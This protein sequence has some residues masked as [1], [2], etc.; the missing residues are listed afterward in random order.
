MGGM[1]QRRKLNGKSLV[2]LERPQVLSTKRRKQSLAGLR[3][4]VG[5]LRRAAG[6]LRRAGET[7]REHSGRQGALR[8]GLRGRKRWQRLGP[9]RGGKGKI[10]GA[11]GREGLRDWEKGTRDCRVGSPRPDS[12]PRAARTARE[13]GASA[14]LTPPACPSAGAAGW[15]GLRGPGR[16]RRRRGAGGGRVGAGRVRS[17]PGGGAGGRWSRPPARSRGAR[18][19]PDVSPA[20]GASSGR[21]ASR[22]YSPNFRG[23]SPLRCSSRGPG[24]SLL[25]E[26]AATAPRSSEAP[27]PGPTRPE[28]RGA[29][30][31]WR[32]LSPT[33]GGGVGSAVR[34]SAACSTSGPARHTPGGSERRWRTEAQ[35]IRRLN[36]R[37]H[38]SD[39]TELGFRSAASASQGGPFT[40][41]LRKYLA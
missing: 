39:A 22:R 1:V 11:R 31:G 14:A 24:L 13:T 18:S 3:V 30:S 10:T 32:L 16:G 33:P 2:H 28:R 36:Q 5:R 23:V 29:G 27:T 41:E 38:S 8:A 40:R 25:G 21:A 6:A 17:A 34:D 7:A 9:V 4:G 26:G 35:E 12:I 20:R 15:S 37:T 19:L